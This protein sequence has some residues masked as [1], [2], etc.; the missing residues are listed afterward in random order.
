MS[1]N[2]C[3][4]STE[5]RSV[6][7]FVPMGDGSYSKPHWVVPLGKEEGGVVDHGFTPASYC[8]FCGTALGRKHLPFETAAGTAQE[9]S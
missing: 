8:P 5:R 4:T 6:T 3:S 1:P 7:L 9:G 2:C